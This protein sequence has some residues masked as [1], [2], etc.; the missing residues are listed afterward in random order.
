ML[1]VVMPRLCCLALVF[2]RQVATGRCVSLHR[3]G[4][5]LAFGFMQASRTGFEED[6]RQG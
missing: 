5:Q 4:K 3:V 1:G 2:L 6:M